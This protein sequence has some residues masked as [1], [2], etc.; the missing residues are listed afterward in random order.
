M[1][2]LLEMKGQ[3]YI[4]EPYILNSVTYNDRKGNENYLLKTAHK[5]DK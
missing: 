2:P 4:F 5:N 3:G 1:T